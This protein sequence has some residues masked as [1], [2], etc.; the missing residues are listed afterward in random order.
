MKRIMNFC[1]ALFIVFCGFFLIINNHTT[2]VQAASRMISLRENKTYSGYDFTRNGKKDRFR[3][4]RD[5][6]R[7]GYV[8]IYLNGKFK[9]RIFIGKGADL[10][11]CGVGT[12]DTYLLV[13]RYLYG[14]HELVV[15]MYSGG[16]FKEVPGRGNLNKVLSYPDFTKI[17]GNTLYV[18]S[19][20]G[21]RNPSSF[22][23]VTTPLKVQTKFKIKN[24]K[25]SCLSWNSQVIGRRT[26][27]ALTSFGTSKNVT[28]LN[29]KNGP[30]INAGQ[31]VTLNYV[32]LG[33]SNYIYQITVNGKTGWVA[34]STG[35]MFR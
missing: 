21:S 10:Y 15:Y 33:G 30:R 25:I 9:Q 22:R 11:W 16:K 2:D 31:K 1:K 28:K 7:Y 3:C 12:K 17:Q 34:N 5:T 27:Y 6:R 13:E 32:R 14:G 35:V 19:T 4:V 8:K 20:P 24:K 26:F 29:V 18:T 23:N